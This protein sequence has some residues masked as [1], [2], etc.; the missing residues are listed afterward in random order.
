[1]DD[2]VKMVVQ[3]ISISVAQSEYEEA[4]LVLLDRVLVHQSPVPKKAIP[5]GLLLKSS[6]STKS[7]SLP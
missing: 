1:M 7:R 3:S 6:A 5:T 4:L 2:F